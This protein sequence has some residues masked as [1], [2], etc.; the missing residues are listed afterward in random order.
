MEMLCQIQVSMSEP[1]SFIFSLFFFSLPL[2]L[3]SGWDFGEKENL[4]RNRARSDR[5]GKLSEK[6]VQ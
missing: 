2:S 5:E 1:F 3:I 4:K 6:E